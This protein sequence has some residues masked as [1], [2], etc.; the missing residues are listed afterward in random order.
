MHAGAPRGTLAGR[1]MR[2]ALSALDGAAQGRQAHREAT[3][4]DPSFK[5]YAKRYFGAGTDWRWFK[6]QGMA[7]SDLTPS[8]RS[9]G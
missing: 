9:R 5:K 7:E 1:A 4:Y 3:R 6:A 8:V 2:G